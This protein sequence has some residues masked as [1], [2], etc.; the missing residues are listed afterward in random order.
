MREH[1]TGASLFGHTKLCGQMP[2]GQAELLRIPFGDSL[3]ITA[4]TKAREVI[5]R[6]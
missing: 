4:P 3:P 1:G 5:Y 2:G 6:P